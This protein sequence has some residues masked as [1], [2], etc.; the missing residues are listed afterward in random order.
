MLTT[1]QVFYAAGLLQPALLAASKLSILILLHRI[2]ITRGFRLTAWILMG[3]VAAW[4]ISITLGAA[5]I[6]LPIKSL[7]DPTVPG[8]CGNQYLFDRIV[9]VPWIVTDFAILVAPLPVIRSLN[10]SMRT[11]VIVVGLFLIGCLYVS[12]MLGRAFLISQ[13]DLHR[14]LRTL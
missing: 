14:E 6:C 7:W 10:M 12:A 2:F 13:Q 9:P 4:Y 5:L 8:H 3:I 1:N 11:K